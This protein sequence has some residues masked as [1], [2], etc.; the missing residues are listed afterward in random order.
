MFRTVY[1]SRNGGARVSNV[2]GCICED[3]V[4]TITDVEGNINSAKCMDILGN[5]LLPVVLKFEKYQWIFPDD[6]DRGTPIR[7]GKIVER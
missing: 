5:N 2:L 3:G 6:S 1:G 4:G 7:T